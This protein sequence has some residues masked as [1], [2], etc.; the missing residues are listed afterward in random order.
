MPVW[1]A[2]AESKNG[3]GDWCDGVVG[4]GIYLRQ[5]RDSEHRSL[6]NA[7]YEGS[8]ESM[9]EKLNIAV[10]GRNGRAEYMKRIRYP[11]K[12]R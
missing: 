10:D 3:I 6:K 11:H 2:S 4:G 9:V 5:K 7:I 12:P 1:E 8:L